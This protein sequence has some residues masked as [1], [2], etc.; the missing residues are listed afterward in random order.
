MVRKVAVKEEIPMKTILWI[1]S[2]TI[3]MIFIIL[4][5]LNMVPS[6]TGSGTLVNTA[7]LSG[8][9]APNRAIDMTSFG[10]IIFFMIMGLY[11]SR[12]QS[13]VA[14]IEKRLPDF[15]H[16]VAEAGRFGMNLADAISV[17]STGKYG[18]LTAEIK[19]MS[20]QIRWGVSVTDVLHQFYERRPTPLVNRIT[21]IIIKANE[22]GGNIADILSLVSHTTKEVQE[23]DSQRKIQM[24]TYLA[25]IYISYFVFIITII[26]LSS[27]FLPEMVKAGQGIAKS[28]AAAL[29]GSSP[30]TISYQ[31]IPE[32]A[33]ILF[34]AVMVH[35]IGDGLMAGVLDTGQVVSGMKHAGIMLLIGWIMMRFLVPQ[36]NNV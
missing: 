2:I 17:A 30:I 4:A 29:G 23:M 22:A 19:K 35:A 34:V 12:E 6:G 20:A 25:V 10:L 8:E 18:S 33:I 14:D 27:T 3:L 11:L 36:F 7:I 9:S 15:L 26:I 16:D 32:I 28:S 21:S 1:V 31:L 13:E 24:S 5:V